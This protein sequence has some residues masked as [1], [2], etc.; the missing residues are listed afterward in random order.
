MPAD[1]HPTPAPMLAT[2][3][4]SVLP[5]GPGWAY[6]F[7]W[8]G[9]RALLDQDDAGRTIYSRN[10]NRI[11]AA[12]PELRSI[13]ADL[14]DVLLDGEIVA[15][16][17]ANSG[18]PSFELLQRRMHVRGTQ[19]AKALA[20]EI[21]VVFVIFDVLRLHGV[22]LTARAYVERRATLDRLAER[23]PDWALSPW[24]DDGP[25]TSEAARLNGLEGIVA[26]RL[27]SRYRPG[28][29]TEDW[30]KIKFTRRQE[31]AVLGWEAGEGGR[32][33][34]IGS[35]LLGYFEDDGTLVYAG[36]VGSG[37]SQA[38]LKMLRVALADLVRPATSLAIDPERAGTRATT[39][40]EPQVV[41]EV[42]FSSWTDGTD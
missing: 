25:A 33:G 30:R 42:E 9:V 7:K 14:G 13:A 6:E 12:Y 21:P 2:P 24:F 28:Q 38:A 32:T 16:D 26:K 36:Q 19:Q 35:L 15:F 37:L 29:R 39:W 18:R 34:D 23:H 41:V 22:D 1:L 27:A 31:F 10:G 17:H 20:A 4:G 11:E 5:T 8:D 40:V 3:S